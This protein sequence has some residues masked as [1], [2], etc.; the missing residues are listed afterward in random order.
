MEKPLENHHIKLVVSDLDGTLLRSDLSISDYTQKMIAQCRA[1]GIQFAFA[2]ARSERAAKPFIDA[3]CPD[4][5]ISNGGA[6]VRVA[7]QIV[8]RKQMPVETTK[9]IIDMCLSL[10]NGNGEIT[11]ETDVGHFWN[12][13]EKPL[14][15][16]IYTDFASF[17]LP[18]Y[19]VTAELESE[20]MAKEI[21]DQFPECETVGFRG[22]KWRRFAI[23]GADKASAICE[24]CKHLHIS[25]DEVV[26][27][28][29]DYNDAEMLMRC[30]IGV[31]MG[32]AIE[33]VKACAD[34]TTRTNNEDGV[35][36]WLEQALAHHCL[37]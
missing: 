20:E 16:Y 13:H 5:I 35:A 29:D 28:G 11:V 8:I 30:G 9:G 31:A 27:F 36:Y 15:S 12:Y 10:T 37:K 26:A 18:A 2:T 1:A 24:L 6:M 19:K 34:Y 14:G 23:K 25:L 21:I 4:I 17:D 7:G 32:N 33:D 22:E 3:I